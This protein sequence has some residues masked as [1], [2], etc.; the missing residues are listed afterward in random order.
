MVSPCSIFGEDARA[1]AD[2]LLA[3]AADSQAA[4]EV[5]A[6][7]DYKIARLRDLARQRARTGPDAAR[8]H[9]EA[10]AGDLTRWIERRELPQPTPALPAPPGDPFGL[11]P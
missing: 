8:A 10:V 11:E 5:R 9:W 2:R 6:M 1:L 4:P 7:A 3:L